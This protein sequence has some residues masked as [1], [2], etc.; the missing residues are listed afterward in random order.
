MS[1]L[2]WGD[3]N[4]TQDLRCSLTSDKQRRTTISL[5]NV[6]TCL[7]LIYQVR[8]WGNYPTSE[9]G[10]PTSPQCCLA[11]VDSALSSFSCWELLVLSCTEPKNC[12]PECIFMLKV[13]QKNVYS[14]WGCTAFGNKMNTISGKTYLFSLCTI[15]IDMKT[16]QFIFLSLPWHS[17]TCVFLHSGKVYFV[18]IRKRPEEISFS[19]LIACVYFPFPVLKS[20]KE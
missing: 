9:R 14:F 8:Y 11:L 3:Q 15:Q 12:G 6:I 10:E 7:D 2:E 17:S 4:W 16:S 5:V 13:R 20:P 18:D 19:L 1:F